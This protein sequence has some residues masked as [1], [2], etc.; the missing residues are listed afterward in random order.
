M[1]SRTLLVIAA[2][3]FGGAV[4]AHAPRFEMTITDRVTAEDLPVYAARG[5]RWVAGTPGNRYSVTLH[6][7]SRDRVLAVL[8]VDGV[9]AISGE[10]A[11]W[12][13]AGYVLGPGERAE[14]RGWRKSAQRVA[15]FEFTAVA[16]SYAALT[17]RPGNVGV[18]G[19]ALFREA[20][21]RVLSQTAPHEAS[22]RAEAPAPAAEAARRD[23][24]S[25]RA[26]SK[27]GTG[28]GRSETSVVQFT[29]FERAQPNPDQVLAIRYDSRAN[30]VA[31]GIIASPPSWRP[32][33]FPGMLGFVPDPPRP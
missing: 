8:S 13:Q 11:A 1:L 17:G 12:D 20:P 33:P 25:A 15:A 14:I 24:G 23:D 28:H 29:R 26:A 10:T 27:L 9:N 32:E 22:D 19:V 21:P 6:N 2:T 18:I 30:L 3:V 7:R 31:M 16:D 4:E 5:E